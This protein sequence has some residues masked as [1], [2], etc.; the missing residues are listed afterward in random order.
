MRSSLRR[1]LAAA[2]VL[3]SLSAWSGAGAATPMPGADGYRV[4]FQVT[5]GAPEQWAALLG[6]IE[7]LRRALGDDL[8]AVE[9]VVHGKGIGLLLRTDTALT[10]RMETLS[11]NGVNFVACENTMRSRNIAKA[12]LLPFVGTVD[13]GVAQV[14]RRQKQGWQ[15][16]R[17]GQ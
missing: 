14:V 12:D 10:D 8:K 11:K 3:L 4:V 5:A 13:S 17:I 9:V 15:Y 1:L 2:F 6:N 16:I 7:N